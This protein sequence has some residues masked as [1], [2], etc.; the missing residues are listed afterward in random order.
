MDRPGWNRLRLRLKR[1]DTVV[2][3]RLDRLGRTTHELAALFREFTERGIRLV[4]ISDSL[5]LSTPTGRLLAHMLASI[6]QFDNEVRGERIKAGQARA[7]ANG[8]RIGGKRKG[9]RSKRVRGLEK[10][11][12]ALY[13]DGSN[14]TEIAQALGVSRPTVY[15]LLELV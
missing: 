9:E 10:P 12:R 6:A 14:I 15:S 2:V 1:G 13:R 7:R 3:H 5:D 8:K 11:A 4:S